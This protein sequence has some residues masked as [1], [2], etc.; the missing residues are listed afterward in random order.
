MMLAWPAELATEITR[1][2]I[3]VEFLPTVTNVDRGVH[4]PGVQCC[5]RCMQHSW[6]SRVVKRI[7]SPTRGGTRWRH[8]EDCRNDTIRRHE[9]ALVRTIICRGR[10]SF[11]ELTATI[12]RCPDAQLMFLAREQLA[13]ARVPPSIVRVVRQG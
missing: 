10:C 12:E 9:E 5:S 11:L 3:D 8:G 1:E 6:H 2:A 13:Q 7:L 4:K